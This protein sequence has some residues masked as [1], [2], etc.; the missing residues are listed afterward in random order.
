MGMSPR[1]DN[2][3][4]CWSERGFTMLD[5]LMI[6]VSKHIE[7]R[8]FNFDRENASGYGL[9]EAKYLQKFCGRSQWVKSVMKVEEMH[10]C[11]AFGLPKSNK[12]ISFGEIN[13]PRNLKP[14]NW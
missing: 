8:T 11:T 3:G 10:H 14:V 13:L 1:I 9:V 5:G 6:T 4:I 7:V 2:Y 12:E